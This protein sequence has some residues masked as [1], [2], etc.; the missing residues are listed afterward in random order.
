MKRS[1]PVLAPQLSPVEDLEDLACRAREDDADLECLLCNRLT[2]TAAA[3]DGLN[4]RSVRFSHC[5]L[6][7]C[8]FSRTGFQD[9]VFECCDC[10]NSLFSDCFFQRVSFAECKGGGG[11]PPQERPAGRPL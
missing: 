5:R 7:D 3:L 6:L 11:K 10:S 1:K 9:V 4:F 2:L 8:D